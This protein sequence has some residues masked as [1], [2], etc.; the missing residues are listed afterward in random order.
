M[1]LL[2]TSAPMFDVCSGIFEQEINSCQAGLAPCNSI[3][4][5]ASIIRS[6]HQIDLLDPANN[7]FEFNGKK[8]IRVLDIEK[9]PSVRFP[10]LENCLKNKDV[11]CISATS[12]NWFL[13]KLMVKRI[14]E[15]DP[16]LPIIAGGIHPT[17]ADRHILESTNVDYIVRGEGEKTLP[18]L[19]RSLENGAPLTGVD[20]IS[21]IENGRIIRNK[22]RQLLMA[23]ELDSNPLPAL[24]LLPSNIYSKVC[25]ETSRGCRFNCT[26]CT[27]A[28]LGAWRSSSPQASLKRIEHAIEYAGKL[29]AGRRELSIVDGNFSD[30]RKRS[31]KIL[32]GLKEMDLCNFGIDFESRVN[33]LIGSRILDLGRDL[34]LDF[35]LVGIEC[36]YESG[37][38]KIRK[39]ID[40]KM[41]EK[42]ATMAKEKEIAIY[43][44]FILGFPWETKEE[45]LKTVA[46]AD[47]L[48]SKYN[49][50]AIMNWFQQFPGSRLWDERKSFGLDDGLELFDTLRMFQK[51]YRLKMSPNL[52]EKDFKDIV[53]DLYKYNMMQLL[54]DCKA[55]SSESVKH[56]NDAIHP[57]H[58]LP[59]GHIIFMDFADDMAYLRNIGRIQRE[60]GPQEQL[61]L[62]RCEKFSAS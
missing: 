42:C 15:L 54:T 61:I 9:E 17:L 37:Q 55:D 33:D 19:L 41:I 36:G 4:L 39:G 40:L 45:C 56:V 62:P 57:S 25:V 60:I 35:I 14:K 59:P 26:F 7:D 31:E 47:K 10:A 13:A 27:L 48:I 21:Y 28:S 6:D 24:D 5:L 3:Y 51:D 49:G 53:A 38:R 29:R 58:S 32:E 52:T 46:F 8:R 11:V 50:V 23:G 22:D 18:E 12:F 43:Y 20:G 44:S 34:P 1:N 16:D 30:D 2:L